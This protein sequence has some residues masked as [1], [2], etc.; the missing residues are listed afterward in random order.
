MG[1]YFSNLKNKRMAESPTPS[2]PQKLSFGAQLAL[3][4]KQKLE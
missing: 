2:A 4:K 3:L 1:S